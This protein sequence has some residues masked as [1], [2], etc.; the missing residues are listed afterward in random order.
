MPAC[1]PC[2]PALR[3]R[4]ALLQRAVRGEAAGGQGARSSAAPGGEEG[5]LDHR[6]AQGRY[7]D[8]CR[9]RLRVTD[10]GGREVDKSESVAPRTEPSVESIEQAVRERSGIDSV[11][12]M[13]A[14]VV[15]C[16]F[17]GRESRWVRRGF[18]RR[19]RRELPEA[20]AD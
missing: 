6:D 12:E 1:V 9:Q 3:S 18:V 16:A 11:V 5:H 13:A 8:R 14:G 17:C 10:Q 19:R 15:R 2:L 7:R 4:S 20:S